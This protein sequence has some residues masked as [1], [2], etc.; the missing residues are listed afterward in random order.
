LAVVIVFS[1]AAE[2]AFIDCSL[3]GGATQVTV[4][5]KRGVPRI[6]YHRAVPPAPV[7]REAAAA[8]ITET[9][10]PIA[11][12]EEEDTP[13]APEGESGGGIEKAPEPS[14]KPEPKPPEEG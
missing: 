1:L 2:I 3:Q 9:P 6:S 11:P 5:E 14:P 4:M 8:P 13:S 7:H 10:E 12:A